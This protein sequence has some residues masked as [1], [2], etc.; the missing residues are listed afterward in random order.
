MLEPNSRQHAIIFFADLVGYT[1]MMEENELAAI[2]RI[3][4][5]K[6]ILN[7]LI[8]SF[9]GA[10]NQFYGD[11][12]LATFQKA[13]DG[14]NCAKQL[15]EN[16]RKTDGLSVRIGLA[17]GQI[18]FKDGNLFGESVNLASRIE[19]ICQPG[20][21]LF[22]KD[23]ADNLSQTED[24]PFK[25]LGK[26][27]FK[28]IKN[29]VEVCG[30]VSPGFPLPDQKD[31]FNN[32]KVVRK[33]NPIF[34]KKL[35]LPLLGL[36]LSLFFVGNYYLQKPS[37]QEINT[38]TIL[39]FKNLGSP[40]Q[41]FFVDG[42]MEAIL[43]NLASTQH[44]KVTTFQAVEKYRNYKESLPTIGA[45]LKSNYI[46]TG[47]VQQLDE[48]VQL[49]VQLVQ[50]PENK[51]IWSNNYKKLLTLENIL[52]LQHEVSL[53]IANELSTPF[54]PAYQQLIENV[55]TENLTAYKIYLKGKESVAK[56]YRTN[57][58]RDL[59][60]AKTF[61][62]EAI[63]VDAEFADSYSELATVYW[64]QNFKANYFQEYFLDSI[65]LLA[66]KALAIN[67]YLYNP[68]QLK[69]SCY[70]EQSRLPLAEQN[71]RRS[72]ELFPNNPSALTQLA[73]LTYFVN[74]NYEE[75]L[76]LLQKVLQFDELANLPGNYERIG[77]LYLDIGAFEQAEAVLAKAH[78]L[79]PSYP[80]I[81][82][83][84]HV[85][86]EFEQ[87]KD[88]FETY[89]AAFPNRTDQT[90]NLAL[91]YMHLEDYEKSLAIWQPFIKDLDTK[92]QDHYLNRVR[93]RYG[94]VLWQL[95]Q[96]EE[97]LK[98]IELSNNYLLKSI[99]LGRMLSS[100]GAA[101]YDIAGNY[102][103]LGNKEKAYEWLDKFDKFGWRWASIHF[104]EVDPLFDNLRSDA[105]FQTLLKRVLKE[106]KK[107]KAKVL[108]VQKKNLPLIYAENQ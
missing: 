76:K 95:G 68:Y 91:A 24:L 2:K 21:V 55:P 1:A 45:A 69:G 63:E 83:A 74:G 19:G 81:G 97:A 34:Q 50:L 5:F 66:D 107:I 33:N 29:P 88:F 51:I 39:P 8:P 53:N 84:Y 17:S 14:V 9:N 79:N 31:I 105:K 46:L 43:N 13:I 38:L 49:G 40:E 96:K 6:A 15:Q 92:G 58:L 94:Y 52:M 36:L 61:F 89:L 28:N 23:I 101:Q 35:L 25:S 16:F 64:L 75:G 32:S 78:E 77:M 41:L 71:M 3:D 7:Q 85:R 103:L 98:Q 42:M 80:G 90:Q 18:V 106:K 104:M 47:S 67:P 27:P 99:Q 70:Y 44:L 37:V 108:N 4:Q 62:Q 59:N 11:G 82:W 10:I 56:Y 100:G 86:G 26:I 22:S 65:L 102:A 60:A 30:L 93:N 12:C 48:S 87:L 73:M 20:G 72:L 57:E 54:S